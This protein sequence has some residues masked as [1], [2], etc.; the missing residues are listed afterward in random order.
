VNEDYKDAL[1][2]CYNRYVDRT[3]GMIE[4][5]DV[6]IKN[7]FNE[8]NTIV[9]YV[10]E[11]KILGYVVFYFRK[12][13]SGYFFMHDMVVTEFVYDTREAL[14]ELCTFFNS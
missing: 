7:M 3:N 4:K 9:A 6:D 8:N 13:H 2:E 1:L 5:R 11:D 14:I 10:K 12:V